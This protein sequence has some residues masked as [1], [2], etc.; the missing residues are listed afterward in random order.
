MNLFANEGGGRRQFSMRF[1]ELSL[2]PALR[3]VP[4]RDLICVK[5][6]WIRLH[7]SVHTGDPYDARIATN[8]RAAR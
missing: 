3:Q 2:S 7:Y 1:S 5:R 4:D 8:R 6:E